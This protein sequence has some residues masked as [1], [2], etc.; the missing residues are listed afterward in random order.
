[1]R[2]TAAFDGSPNLPDQHS[3]NR[4]DDVGLRSGMSANCNSQTHG[5]FLS[6]ENDLSALENEWRD[7]EARANIS[8][9]QRYDW[10]A[11]FVE[12][13]ERPSGARVVIVTGRKDGKLVFILPLA[14]EG[15]LIPQYR[16]IGGSH[17]NF[18][19]ALI[20]R[21]VVA[22]LDKEKIKDIFHHIAKLLP[23]NG[24]LKLCCQPDTWNRQEN[25]LLALPRQASINGAFGA[26]L[27][28]GFDN[29]LASG[30]GKRKRKKFRAQMRAVEKLGGA[31]LVEA[32]SVTDVAE[33][34]QCF[35]Q[36]KS[37]RLHQQGLSDVFGG[38]DTKVF[39]QQ[40]ATGALNSDEPVLKLYALEVGGMY[41]AICGGGV[42]NRHFST[43]FTSFA[44]DELA[45]ISPGE[46]LWYML[47]EHLAASGFH[48]F[49]LGC[50][51]E[52]FKRSWCPDKIAMFD[53]V[54][55]LSRY[56]LGHVLAHRVALIVKRR[57]RSNALMW[58]IVRRG[59][60]AITTLGGQ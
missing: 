58:G 37:E 2:E 20:D 52:R 16:W 4:G 21:D 59:R 43:C 29:L 55:P 47:V 53:V 44:N 5:I 54:I 49:D 31:K 23:G 11:P 15:G 26:D 18:N 17:S 22:A 1:M 50:G 7:L 41:Q 14:V 34:L 38:N 39:L 57:V 35:Y 48:S 6:I 12:T 3:R 8:I 56:S 33:I 24:Y 45:P 13:I 28:G 30:N 46:L 9:Y 42:I 19:M 10:V 60:M 36:Q 40:M 25:P 27:S 51:E 32:K